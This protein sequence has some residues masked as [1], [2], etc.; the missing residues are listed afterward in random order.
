MIHIPKAAGTNARAFFDFW[1]GVNLF[2]H[3]RDNQLG[4]LPKKYDLFQSS[5]HANTSI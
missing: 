3:Y 4:L 1:F 2:P 5:E